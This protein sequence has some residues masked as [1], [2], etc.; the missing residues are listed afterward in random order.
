MVRLAGLL[1]AP[2]AVAACCVGVSSA[3]IGVIRTIPVGRY[4]AGVSSDGTHVWVTN[5]G[6]GS[7]SEIP[8]SY[9]VAAPPEASIEFPA[10]GATYSQ[11]AA[12]TTRFSC[13]EAEDGPGIESCTDSNGA[14]GASG[15]LETST[16]GPHTYTVTAKSKDGQTGMASIGYTVARAI[17]A[18][19]TGTVML[20]PGLTD[21]AAVQLMK[22]KGTLTGCAGRPFTELIFTAMLTTSS[23]VSCSV[24]TGSGEAAT[25]TAKYKWRPKAKVSVGTLSMLLTEAPGNASLGEVTIGPYSPLTFA[26]TVREGYSGGVTCG[27]KVGRKAVKAVKNGTFSGSA[28]DFE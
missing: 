22:V 25:G 5:T 21:T 10:G 18:G 4:P 1:I 23:P 27:D 14:S 7:V 20:S 28:V 24:L 19:N 16:I 8:T 11:G 9:A 12:V 26:G 6:E 15:A 3:A 13:T 17:C 2:A